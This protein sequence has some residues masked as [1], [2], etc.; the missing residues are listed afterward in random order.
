MSKRIL[1]KGMESYDR[2]KERFCTKKRESISIIKKKRK[3]IYEF[4]N[5][6]LKKEYIKLSKSSQITLVFFVKK[7]KNKKQMV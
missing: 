4:I 5:K 1:I 7:K 2:Y 3:A 6:Q